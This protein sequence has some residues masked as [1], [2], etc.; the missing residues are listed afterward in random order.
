MNYRV[1][2]DDPEEEY[3]TPTLPRLLAPRHVRKPEAKDAPTSA[4]STLLKKRDASSLLRSFDPL[5]KEPSVPK[6]DLQN[7]FHRS[8]LNIHYE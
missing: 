4:P 1:G 6:G 7:I 3:E 8:F 5:L 2:K